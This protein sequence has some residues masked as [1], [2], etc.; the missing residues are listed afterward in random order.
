MDLFTNDTYIGTEIPLV[1]IPVDGRMC[2]VRP[3]VHNNTIDFTPLVSTCDILPHIAR[4][5]S[6]AVADTLRCNTPRSP[7]CDHVS[8]TVLANNDTLTMRI[9]PCH[10]PPAIQL[11]NVAMNGTV[12]FNVTQVNS[13]QSPI[14]VQ[15]GDDTAEINITIVHRGRGLSLGVMVSVLCCSEGSRRFL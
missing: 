13:T 12:T 11:M 15:I 1:V 5:A 3:P 8:C 6:A 4:D 9:L 7:T 14:V 10:A 2:H